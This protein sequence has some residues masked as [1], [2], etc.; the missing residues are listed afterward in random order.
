MTTAIAATIFGFFAFKL[1]VMVNKAD[2]K[3]SKYTLFKDLSHS[4]EVAYFSESGID[5]ALGSQ[6]SPITKE[7]G[8]L[9]ITHNTWRWVY[10]Q[11]TNLT[12]LHISSVNLELA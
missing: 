12:D 11:T 10:N 5:F 4:S 7:Y 1:N 9:R 6:G 2:T 3:I 8:E